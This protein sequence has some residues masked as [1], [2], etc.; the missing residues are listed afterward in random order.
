MPPRTSSARCSRTPWTTDC[1]AAKGSFDLA[2]LVQVLRDIGFDGP[3]GVEILSTS[4]RALPVR[5][6][7]LNSPQSRRAV[8]SLGPVSIEGD[9]PQSTMRCDHVK[10]PVTVHH[11]E[12][13]PQSHGSDLAVDQ[14]AARCFPHAATSMDG[15]GVLRIPQWSNGSISNRCRN[16]RR[17][18]ATSSSV[19]P[20]SSSIKTTSGTT[21]AEPS[22]MPSANPPARSRVGVLKELDP[23]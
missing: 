22:V 6:A 19:V 1:S 9:R 18:A 15:R 10:V 21:S 11:I 2:G 4:F 3:W 7:D 20:T 12:I 14:T 13:E 23:D 8:G 5:E 16:R 17:T